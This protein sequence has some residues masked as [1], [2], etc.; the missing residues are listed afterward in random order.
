M[1][2]NQ[3]KIK[4]YQNK[5]IDFFNK[6]QNFDQCKYNMLYYNKT[7]NRWETVKKYAKQR[8][9]KT[10]TGRNRNIRRRANKKF[11]KRPITRKFRSNKPNKEFTG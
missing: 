4:I 6:K 10:T 9:Y 2:K 1:K 7:N 11:F 3:N 8:I 5:V